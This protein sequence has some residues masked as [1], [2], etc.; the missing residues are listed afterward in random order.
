MLICKTVAEVKTAVADLR[1]AG[2]VGLVTTMGALHAGHMA[3]VAAAARDHASVV[4]TIFVNPTQFG[5]AKDLENYPRTEAAD[6]AMLKAAGVA[7][8]FM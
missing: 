7:A 1:K 2:T 5:D 6:L 3:L 4:A 8:V